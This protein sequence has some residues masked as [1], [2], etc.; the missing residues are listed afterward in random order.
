MIKKILSTAAIFLFV[1]SATA[2]AQ[3]KIAYMNT[4][5]V[6][7]ELPE[8]ERVEQ[9][10]NSFI[11]QKQQELQQQSTEY[12]DAVAQYQENSASMSQ[13]QIEQQEQELTDMQTELDEMNQRIRLEVQQKRNELLEP[14][15]TQVDEAIAAI[16]ESEGFDFVLNKSTNTGENIIFYA[17]DGQTNITQ[18][19]IDRLTSTQ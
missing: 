19:V 12:Q 18:A 17:G 10:L 3:V 15:L 1:L 8:R 6:L 4:Q 14:I 13:Q 9:E 16:S 2:T 5:E 11:Q 7:N